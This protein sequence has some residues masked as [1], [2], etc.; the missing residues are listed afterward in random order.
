MS[1]GEILLDN[2]LNLIITLKVDS[3]EFKG[4]VFEKGCLVKDNAENSSE[5]IIKSFEVRISKWDGKYSTSEIM[6]MGDNEGSMIS[7]VTKL[8]AS[9]EV[10]FKEK[11]IEE[12]LV[13]HLNKK[14]GYNGFKPIEIGTEVFEKNDTYYFKMK[15]LKGNN[16]VIQKFYRETLKPCIDFI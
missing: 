10:S 12:V 7:N 8:K 13:G 5:F 1:S 6:V 16:I 3:I 2:K 15:P 4:V 11:E 9:D 14:F